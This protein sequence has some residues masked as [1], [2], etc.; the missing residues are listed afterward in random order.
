MFVLD[1]RTC[2]V[3]KQKTKK[4]TVTMLD[5]VVTHAIDYFHVLLESIIAPVYLSATTLCAKWRMITSCTLVF[6]TLT[7]D[8]KRYCSVK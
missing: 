4:N 3:Q 5:C 2:R 1:K 6:C 8:L 7:K